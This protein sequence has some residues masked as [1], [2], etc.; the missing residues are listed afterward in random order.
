MHGKKIL[1]KVLHNF[2]VAEITVY[3][4][5]KLVLRKIQANNDNSN[6]NEDIKFFKM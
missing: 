3:V 4:R 6:G 5:I 2:H 1:N